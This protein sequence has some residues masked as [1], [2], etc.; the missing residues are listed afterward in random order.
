VVAEVADA[1]LR[2]LEEP[3]LAGEQIRGREPV[4]EA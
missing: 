3:V 2:R 1:L 4:D